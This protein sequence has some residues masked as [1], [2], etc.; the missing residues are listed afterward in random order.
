MIYIPWYFVHTINEP[1]LFGQIYFGITCISLFWGLYVGT[2]VD[3]YSRKKLFMSEN[4]FGACVF[5]GIGLYTILSG[6]VFMP[7]VGLA[8]ACTFFIYNLHYPTLYAFAQELIEKENYSKISTWLEVQG[9]LTTVGGGA[10]AALLMAGLSRGETSLLGFSFYSP[11]HIEKWSLGQVFLLDGITYLLSCILISFIKYQPTV[12]RFKEKGNVFEQLK[13]GVRF[14]KKNPLIFVFGNAAYF[15]FV[16]ILVTNYQ[17]MPNFIS[18][19]LHGDGLAYALADMTYALGAVGAGLS[20]RFLFKRTSTV[21]GNIL[22]TLLG[23]LVFTS[24][25]FTHELSWLYVLLFFLA[26]SNSGSRIMRVVYILKRV[27]NQVIGRTQSVFQVINVIQRLLFIGLFTLPFFIDKI[28]WS[29]GI[30]AIGAFI[31]ACLLMVYYKR[32]VEVPEI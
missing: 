4:F 24:M 11:I 25:A 28:R 8:F 18:N 17:L 29:F 21:M 2:L 32:L 3:K 13:I 16:T 6:E 19:V 23:V 20:T 7:L 12:N 1:V 15:I 30:F 26:V 10:V 27:P 14:L 5:G 31:A 22:L 9:Q